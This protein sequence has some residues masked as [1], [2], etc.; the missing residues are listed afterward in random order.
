MKPND[1]SSFWTF[2]T[3]NSAETYSRLLHKFTRAILLTGGAHVLGYEFPLTAED[4]QHV[5]KLERALKALAGSREVSLEN[6]AE[7]EDQSDNGDEDK[8]EAEVDEDEADEMYELDGDVDDDR[9]D[10]DDEGDDEGENDSSSEPSD[11]RQ[12]LSKHEDA[13]LRAFHD[14]FKHFL[15]ITTDSTNDEDIK[16]SNVLECLMAIYTLQEDGN[17]WQPSGVSQMFATLHY[18][19]RGAIV[20]EAMR[21]RECNP[22]KYPRLILYVFFFFIQIFNCDHP[23]CHCSAVEELCQKNF[24]PNAHSPFNIVDD[25]QTVATGLAKS[26]PNSPPTTIVHDGGKLI[27]YKGHR[28][29]VPV[30]QAALQEFSRTLKERIDAFCYKTDFGL[31]I[32][33]SVPDDWTETKRG[34]SWIHNA[35]FSPNPD[36]LLR[37]KMADPKLQLASLRDTEDGTVLDFNAGAVWQILDDCAKINRDLAVFAFFTAG[38]TPRITEFIPHKHAN[39]SCPQTVFRSQ[40]DLWLVTWW[41]RRCGCRCHELCTFQ[42]VTSCISK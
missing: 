29:S 12:E 17:F 7:V 19:I 26:G 33:D 8:I 41:T 25:Y 4:K 37:A 30:W 27:D 28:L 42:P 2:V 11:E 9:G 36:A 21:M 35:D 13:A 38:Q 14:F 15:L 1:T 20:Y 22:T 5:L 18:H 24:H 3:K 34:Y 10:R 39:S 6:S 32:P 40:K 23:T 31:R 16:W